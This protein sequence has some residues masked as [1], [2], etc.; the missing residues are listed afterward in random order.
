M[1]GLSVAH[2][3]LALGSLLLS[4]TLS[5]GIDAEEALLPSPLP[6]LCAGATAVLMQPGAALWSQL[7]SGESLPDALEWLLVLGN[8]LLWG[9]CAALLLRARQASPPS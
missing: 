8:S 6:E 5:G 4:L 9:G 2:F 7:Q 1:L 3:V